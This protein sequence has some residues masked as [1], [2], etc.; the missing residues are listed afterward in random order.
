MLLYSDIYYAGTPINIQV[1]GLGP[2]MTSQVSTGG[3]LAIST[4]TGTP[5]QA[6]PFTV[7]GSAFGLIRQTNGVL[8]VTTQAPAFD[9]SVAITPSTLTAE[10]GKTA[11]YMVIVSLVSGT[12]QPVALNLAGL[13][14]DIKYSFSMMS[15]TPPY[16]S[17]LTLDLSS[18]TSAGTYNMIVTGSGAGQAKTA[19]ATLITEKTADFL[20]SVAPADRRIRQGESTSLSVIVNNLGQFNDIVTLTMSGLPSGA[21]PSFN[22]ASGKPPFTAALTISTTQSI[23]VGTY[24]ARIDASGGGKSHSAEVTIIVEAAAV[25]P[26][27]FVDSLLAN[28]LNLLLIIIVILLAVLILRSSRRGTKVTSQ[29]PETQTGTS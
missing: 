1:V 7:I 8:V 13:P 23:P 19:S 29:R 5:P 24:T 3:L 9:Y 22:P 16:S 2:G 10:L 12:G 20:I 27:S 18:A 17:T 26:S 15:G 6:Y 21:S 25:S 14:A 11:S 4:S 28:P